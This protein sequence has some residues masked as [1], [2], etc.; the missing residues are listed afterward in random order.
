MTWRNMT[1]Q[2]I[3][4][5][6]FPERKILNFQYINWPTEEDIELED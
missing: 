4:E 5:V 3:S 6:G 2:K 1:Q